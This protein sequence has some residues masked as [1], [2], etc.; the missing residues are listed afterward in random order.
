MF[1][2][3]TFN[4]FEQK[5]R[6]GRGRRRR[7]GA[8][9]RGDWMIFYPEKRMRWR[10]E[11]SAPSEGIKDQKC[12]L[13]WVSYCVEC[14]IRMFKRYVFFT[15]CSIWMQTHSSLSLMLNQSQGDS[16]NTGGLR[17]EQQ[18]FWLHLISNYLLT[19]K[20][21]PSINVNRLN[22]V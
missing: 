10:H 6:G 15:P 18:K 3:L 7:R 16:I 12:L 14:V 20:S 2:L 17:T 11:S 5:E 8:W 13:W 9:E 21:K 19:A 4:Y 1:K 22:L